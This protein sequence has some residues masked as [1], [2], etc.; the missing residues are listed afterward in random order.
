MQYPKRLIEVDLP[1]ERISVHARREKS[2]RHGHISTVRGTFIRNSEIVK[3]VAERQ[4]LVLHE[5]RSRALR[6]QFRRRLRDRAVGVKGEVSRSYC[7]KRCSNRLRSFAN[8]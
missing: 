5:R 2:I 6:D 4:G 1:S 8:G 3:V 7:A